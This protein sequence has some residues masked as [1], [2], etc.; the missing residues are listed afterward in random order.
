MVLSS[1][2]E[3]V[4]AKFPFFA[5]SWHDS[6]WVLSCFH[7]PGIQLCGLPGGCLWHRT[8]ALSPEGLFLLFALSFIS[9]GS[10]CSWPDVLLAA[11]ITTSLLG[12]FP[13]LPAKGR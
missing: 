8:E 7:G 2:L 1:Y 13:L 6:C 11:V 3:S 12:A 10:S 9:S 5:C 4:H